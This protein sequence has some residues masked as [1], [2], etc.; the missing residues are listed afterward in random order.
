MIEVGDVVQID[1]GHDEV[2][3]GCFMVVTEL[4]PSW[5]GLMGYISVPGKGDQG[6]P[7]YY[8]IEASK[9]LRIGKAEWAI[10]ASDDSTL[11]T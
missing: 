8:R 7:A 2:F 5:N 11:V 3:G 4:K 9:V 6:G 10:L 1:P